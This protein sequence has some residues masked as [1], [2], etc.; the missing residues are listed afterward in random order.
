[1]HSLQK[2]SICPCLVVGI[3]LNSDR[4]YQ[5]YKLCLSEKKN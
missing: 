2:M 4:I 1:M 3:I 5:G